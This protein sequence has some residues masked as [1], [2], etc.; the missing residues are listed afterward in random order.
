VRLVVNTTLDA[1]REALFDIISDPRRRPE[2]QSSLASV[3]VSTEGPPGLGTAWYELTRGGL[4]F[5]LE[6]TEFER[7][8]RWAEQ[9]RGR[10]ANARLAVSLDEEP[11]ASSTRVVVYVEVDFKG[12]L[13]LA[14]P[15]VR[16]LMPAALRADLRRVE[17]LA[18]A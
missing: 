9:A 16:L 2:W 14:A 7:P 12:P 8:V 18:R 1:T 17:A 3:H 5:D 15:L 13:K 4:R 11:S 10:I 6:I